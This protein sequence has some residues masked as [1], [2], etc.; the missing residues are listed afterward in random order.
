VVVQEAFATTATCDFADLL[1]PA[2]TWGEK[3][4]TVT[5]SERRI[6]RFVRRCPSPPEPGTTGELPPNSRARLERKLRPGRIH[7]VPLF[8]HGRRCGC[9]SHLE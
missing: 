4:G 9:A 3:T 1:L 7:P 2:T 8:P 6:S 5:N